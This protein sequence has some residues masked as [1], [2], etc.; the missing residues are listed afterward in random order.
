[1]FDKGVVSL[2]ALSF[3]SSMTMSVSVELAAPEKKVDNDVW[4]PAPGPG[5][6]N[7]RQR[8]VAC[9]VVAII[10]GIILIIGAMLLDGHA[11]HKRELAA[12]NAAQMTADDA[13]ASL[14][15]QCL[16]RLE[17]KLGRTVPQ[18]LS[19]EHRIWFMLCHASLEYDP[20]HGPMSVEVKAWYDGTADR[21]YD[22]Y[23]VPLPAGGP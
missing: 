17:A 14:Q 2:I 12:K 16:I 6:M 10:L 9:T 23:L 3:S 18:P 15:S 5:T 20:E 22:M 4:L 13:L 1:M 19:R 21:I 7:P 8:A 11:S